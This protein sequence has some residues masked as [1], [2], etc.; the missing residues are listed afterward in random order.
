MSWWSV[1]RKKKEV[2]LSPIDFSALKLDM[3]S[4]LIPKI[5]DGSQSMDQTIAM[6]AKFQDL[7]FERLV[8]TPHVM[9]D[10]YRNTPEI[11]LEGLEKVRQTAKEIGLKIQIDAAAEYYFDDSLMDRLKKKEKLLT[12]YGN[13]VLFEFSMVTEP[14]NIDELVFELIT[15]NYVPVLAHYERYSFYLGDIE[16]AE[17]LR[18]QGVKIQVNLLSLTGHYGSEIQK[19]AENLIDAKLV[20][21]VAS[22]CHRIEHLMKIEKGRTLPYFHKIMDLDLLNFQ[23][24]N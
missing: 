18:E 2:E 10:Y 16:T 6:L 24:K 3:H 19:Q 17:K 12:F 9:S 1:F 13:Y 21:F 22:D 14:F 15:Q 20:D 5:D 23:L 8:T 7:G 11:I 4:H